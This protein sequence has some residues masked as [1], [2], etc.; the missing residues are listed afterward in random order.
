MYYV[1]LVRE[2]ILSLL[3]KSIKM[4]AIKNIYVDVLNE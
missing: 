1:Y 3:A 2:T 4:F